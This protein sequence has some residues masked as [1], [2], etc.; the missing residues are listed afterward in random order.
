MIKHMQGKD[1][2]TMV[3]VGPCSIHDT[4]KPALD[5]AKR[6]A[7]QQKNTATSY[8]IVTRTYF[9]KPRTNIG[10]KG[11]IND[12]DLDNSYTTLNLAYHKAA[13]KLC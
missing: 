1:P 5:Y 8:L 6:L 4:R 3:I 12:P 11:L 7:P 13:R 10:W 2:R 9:E